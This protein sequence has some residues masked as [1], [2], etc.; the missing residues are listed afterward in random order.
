[1]GVLVAVILFTRTSPPAPAPV[2]ATTPQIAALPPTASAPAGAALAA[3]V[4]PA[5]TGLPAEA[6]LTIDSTPREVEIYLGKEKLGTSA[7]PL[8]LRRSDEKVKLTFKAPGF[9]PQDIEVSPS[10]HARVTVSL[11]KISV[12]VKKKPGGGDLEY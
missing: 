7:R 2:V 10:A 3:T 1:M 9:A 6:E 8:R 12:A 4:I 5:P 11:V